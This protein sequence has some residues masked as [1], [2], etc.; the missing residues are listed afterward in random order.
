MRRF[1]FHH[2]GRGRALGLV[3][4]IGSVVSLAVLGALPVEAGTRVNGPEARTARHGSAAAPRSTARRP[5][6]REAPSPRRRSAAA[7]PNWR[8]IGQHRSERPGPRLLS[9]PGFQ[10][11]GE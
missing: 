6:S 1:G 9:G 5:V 4:L 7:R 3:A 10:K 11:R 2:F 8:R